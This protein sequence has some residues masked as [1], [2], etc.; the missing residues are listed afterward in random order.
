MWVDGVLEPLQKWF[1]LWSTLYPI[2]KILVP[3]RLDIRATTLL[4]M[5]KTLLMMLK[6]PEMVLKL[7]WMMEKPLMG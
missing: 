5:L 6:T 3:T 7:L 1:V 4:T 2:D